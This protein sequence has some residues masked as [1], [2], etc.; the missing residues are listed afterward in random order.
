[1]VVIVLKFLRPFFQ[2]TSGFPIM[3][4]HAHALVYKVNL[5]FNSPSKRDVW[6]ETKVVAPPVE[7]MVS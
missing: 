2:T 3:M 5:A 7:E 1:M 6:Y 4:A